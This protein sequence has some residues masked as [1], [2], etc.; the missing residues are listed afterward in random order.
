MYIFLYKPEFIVCLKI[1]YFM[2]VIPK[3]MVWNIIIITD[4]IF[5]MEEA[6]SHWIFRSTS[7]NI[8]I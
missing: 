5:S 3:I 6:V 8:V 1:Q 2:Q 4:L 7:E